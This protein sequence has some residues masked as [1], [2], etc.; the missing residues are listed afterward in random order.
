MSMKEERVLTPGG[1]G[2]FEDDVAATV[3]SGGGGGASWNGACD[4]GAEDG[5]SG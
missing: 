2:I 4:A 5:V 3:G 1:L